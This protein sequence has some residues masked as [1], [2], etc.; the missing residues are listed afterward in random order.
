[1]IV[2]L[3]GQISIR[4]SY[5]EDGTAYLLTAIKHFMEVIEEQKKVLTKDS[6]NKRAKKFLETHAVSE[7]VSITIKKF[8]FA[9]LPAIFRFV[10]YILYLNL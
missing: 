6:N 10:Q 3:Q 7:I 1:M 8:N 4:K 5:W 9:F 2:K